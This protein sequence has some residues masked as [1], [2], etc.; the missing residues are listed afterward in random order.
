MDL[1]SSVSWNLV[2]N[3][4]I[5][6][7]MVGQV[8]SI[9]SASHWSE[10]SQ[11]RISSMT[12]SSSNFFFKKTSHSPISENFVPHL[13]RLL[14][15]HPLPSLTGYFHKGDYNVIVVDYGSLVVVPCM[16]Q[17]SW[18]PSF[19]GACIAQLA[20]YL[21]QH[22]RGVPTEKLHLLGWSIGAHIAGLTANYIEKGRKLGRITGKWALLCWR[23][24]LHTSVCLDYRLHIMR[25]HIHT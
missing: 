23:A 20:F 21:A 5:H 10:S 9:G 18:S 24:Q 13:T 25:D 19:A 6:T 4:D 7:Y 1:K 14:K 16:D 3:L 15:I 8:V 11:G 22:P 17:I 2:Q 12:R